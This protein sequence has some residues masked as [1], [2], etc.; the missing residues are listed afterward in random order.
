MTASLSR[1]YYDDLWQSTAMTT[2]ACNAATT[3]TTTATI[4]TITITYT[5][6]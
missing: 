6:T 1:H 5:D 3:S 4:T 2:T